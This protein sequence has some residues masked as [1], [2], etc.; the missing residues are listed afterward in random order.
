MKNKS[1]AIDN[2]PLPAG[3]CAYNLSPEE[4]ADLYLYRTNGG[5]GP[6]TVPLESYLVLAALDF[7]GCL[8]PRE[9]SLVPEEK[10]AGGEEGS[11]EI[12]L[13]EEIELATV[14]AHPSTTLPAQVR[15]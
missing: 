9:I 2:G 13:S 5:G 10:D 1:D 12:Q 4:A 7:A 14:A 3:G 15:E 11:S 6:T 8:R